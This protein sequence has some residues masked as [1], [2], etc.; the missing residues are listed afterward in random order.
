MAEG[1]LLTIAYDPPFAP[2][3]LLDPEIILDTIG[4]ISAEYIVNRASAEDAARIRIGLDARA[5]PLEGFDFLY[6]YGEVIAQDTG[7]EPYMLAQYA[8]TTPGQAQRFGIFVAANC[9]ADFLERSRTYGRDTV[10]DM[11]WLR[12]GQIL[13]NGA[14]DYQAADRAAV[15]AEAQTVGA[16]TS[17]SYYQAGEKIMTELRAIAA[18]SFSPR[19]KAEQALRFWMNEPAEGPGAEQEARFGQEHLRTAIYGSRQGLEERLAQAEGFVKAVMNGAAREV[20][21]ASGPTNTVP[22]EHYRSGIRR[23]ISYVALGALSAVRGIT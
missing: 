23:A 8:H 22:L 18:N 9:L 14:A 13:Q 4:A 5:V 20:P 21:E 7:E 19:E 2:R 17:S 10:C 16:V 12:A 1:E 6:R 3:A 11:A 15:I